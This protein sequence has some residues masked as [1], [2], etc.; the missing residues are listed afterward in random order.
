M[1][2]V[3]HIPKFVTVFAE[4]I[5]LSLRMPTDETNE[6]GYY[7]TT[8]EYCMHACSRC[9]VVISNIHGLKSQK[10]RLCIVYTQNGKQYVSDPT[11]IFG[12]QQAK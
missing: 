12:Y 11:M 4:L 10:A 8:F 5:I 9:M 1:S 2:T 6:P 7:Q 3:I